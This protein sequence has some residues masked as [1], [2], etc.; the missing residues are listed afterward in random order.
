VSKIDVNQPQRFVVEADGARIEQTVVP[1]ADR[2]ILRSYLSGDLER[3]RAIFRQMDCIPEM[4]VYDDD[5][6]PFEQ[7]V[8]VNGELTLHAIC[9]TNIGVATLAGKEH[10]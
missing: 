3:C 4:L 8:Y 5:P 7:Y 1:Q 6:R 10:A 2:F 9:T